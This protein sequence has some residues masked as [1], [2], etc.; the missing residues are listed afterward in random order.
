MKTR[1]HHRNRDATAFTLIELLIS[2]AILAAIAV[3]MT[4]ILGG[5]N[6]VWTNGDQRVQNFQAGRAVTDLISRELSQAAISPRL[7]FVQ[8]PTVPTTTPVQA[9]NSRSLFW[10]APLN[11]TEGKANCEVGYYLVRDDANA[12]YQLKRLLIPPSDT[13][14]F[15]IYNS[16]PSATRASWVTNADFAANSSTVADGVIALWFRCFD[17][18]GDPIPWLFSNT[19]AA[20]PI[21]FNSAA[22]FQWQTGTS[23]SFTY[24][25]TSTAQAHRL[26]AS[27]EVTIVTLDSTA[28]VRKPVI[29]PIPA[30]TD[31]N[32]IPVQ[33]AAFNASLRANGI[34]S[35]RTFTTRI[36][37]V[38]S[39]K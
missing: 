4:N 17:G 19:G 30:A 28:L 8:D 12:I 32:N 36:D 13:T 7:Q 11:T 38:N 16:P 23:S 15:L 35:A 24:T 2:M 31:V 18:N 14:Q 21:T 29:P 20:S 37:L 39:Q 10:Q 27:V 25:G 1:P 6:R 3:L 5:V 33:V 34:Q 22:S 9:P 26:P